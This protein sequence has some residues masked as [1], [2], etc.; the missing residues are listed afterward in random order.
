M[1][2][3]T[4]IKG[5]LAIGKVTGAVGGKG[6]KNSVAPVDA[7]KKKMPAPMSKGTPFMKKGKK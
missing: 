7:P 3:S 5:N 4:G 6:E 1:K 2:K